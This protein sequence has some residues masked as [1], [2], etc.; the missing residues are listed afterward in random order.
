[1]MFNM[2][3]MKNISMEELNLSQFITEKINFSMSSAYENSATRVVSN[4]SFQTN[5]ATVDET[6]HLKIIVFN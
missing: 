1:M 2:S 6:L 4:L 3:M 5:S